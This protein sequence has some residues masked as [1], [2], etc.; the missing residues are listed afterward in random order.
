MTTP[1][2]RRSLLPPSSGCRT[3]YVGNTWVQIQGNIEALASFCQTA[4]RNRRK[5][6]LIYCLAL[7]IYPEDRG[8][9]LLRNIGLP[10]IYKALQSKDRTLTSKTTETCRDD[11]IMASDQMNV[12][13]GV[14]CVP[15]YCSVNDEAKYAVRYPAAASYPDASC[16]YTTS[17]PIRIENGDR[18]RA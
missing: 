4:R 1:T 17:C 18:A 2:F 12:W 15:N 11:Q 8:R 10:P 9:I 6:Q 14:R 13:Y 3:S 7:L 5:D 16:V